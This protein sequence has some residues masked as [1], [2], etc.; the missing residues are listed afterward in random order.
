MTSR[1]APAKVSKVGPLSTMRKAR[2]DVER[3]GELQLAATCPGYLWPTV[4]TLGWLWP[5]AG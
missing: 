1:T 5:A 4:A 3:S 2:L